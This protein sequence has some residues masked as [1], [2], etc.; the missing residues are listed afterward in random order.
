MNQLI[1]LDM[2]PIISL[3]SVTVKL[4]TIQQAERWLICQRYADNTTD[5]VELL[6][7]CHKTEHP[8]KRIILNTLIVTLS[9]DDDDADGHVCMNVIADLFSRHLQ[10][11][12]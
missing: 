10:L 7:K 4:I 1:E 11:Y 3:V 9:D 5:Y 2:V 12:V 6:K 8:C